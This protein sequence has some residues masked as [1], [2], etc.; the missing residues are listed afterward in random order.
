MDKT[1]GYEFHRKVYQH[2]N[3]YI[4]LYN[5]AIDGGAAKVEMLEVIHPTSVYV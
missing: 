3:M 2:M 5:I 1:T 4:Y